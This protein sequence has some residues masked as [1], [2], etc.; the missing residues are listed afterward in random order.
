MVDVTIS[1][2]VLVEVPPRALYGLLALR[3]D[4]FVV[5]QGINCHELDGRDLETDT[6]LL[7]IEQNGIVVATLRILRDGDDTIR[8]GRVA[9]AFTARGRGLAA[10]LVRRAIEMAGDW[11]IVLDAQAHLVDWYGKFGFVRAG[12]DFD[13]VGIAHTPMRLNSAS[14]P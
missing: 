13:E 2:A 4:V 8:I 3:V 6:R 1:D 9:T 12:D 5:E 14:L 7:W 11:P 10:A